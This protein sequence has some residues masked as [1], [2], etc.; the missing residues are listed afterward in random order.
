MK[1]IYSEKE[2]L[3]HPQYEWNEGKLKPYPEKNMRAEIIKNEAVKYGMGD[4][5]INAKTFSEKYIKAV[6]DLQMFNFIKSCENLNKDESVFPHV[7]PYTDFT[8]KFKRHPR[9]NL[10]K[11]GYYCFDVGIEIDKHTYEAAKA[12][13][14]CALTGAELITKGK[15]KNVFALSRPPGHHAGFDHFGGYCIFNNAAVAA[16]ELVKTY[17]MVSILDLDFHHGNGT[18]GIFYQYPNVLYAS[19]H[20]DPEEYYP[21]FSGFADEKGEKLGLGANLNIPLGK[22]IKNEDYRAHLKKALKE[23]KKFG[24][25]VLVLSMGFDTYKDDPIG[26]FDLTTEFY[27][28]IALLV[29][30]LQI[31]VLAVLEG[32]YDIADLQK[33]G[34]SFIKGFAQLD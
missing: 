18:Q 5:I 31:P 19:I 13:V 8:P 32:G 14:D 16:Y 9:I 23:I 29:G 30:E 3:H 24:A 28:E 1:I 10:Q 17:G 15:E 7:F 34:M 27:E 12:A 22:G 25:K 26:D 33:N 11:S 4:K 20:G 6:T 21:Y 2:K